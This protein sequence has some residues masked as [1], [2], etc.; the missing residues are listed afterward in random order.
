ME[1]LFLEKTVERLDGAPD[2]ALASCWIRLFGDEEW[3]WRRKR[4]DLVMLPHECC[5]GTPAL[6]RRSAVLEVGDFDPAM[7]LGHEDWDLWL[8]IVERGH[9]GVIVPEVL[10]LYQRRAESRGSVADAQ[11][12]YLDI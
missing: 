10:F 3:D 6:V 4:C 1:P 12:L 2:A 9:R 7:E 11:G 5:V 8:S